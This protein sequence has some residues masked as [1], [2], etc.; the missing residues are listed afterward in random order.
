[1]QMVDPSFISRFLDTFEPFDRKN[2]AQGNKSSF[3]ILGNFFLFGSMMQ[4]VDLLHFQ[5][6]GY[7]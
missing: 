7:I 6:F 4:M 2:C 3:P 1:M 5:V